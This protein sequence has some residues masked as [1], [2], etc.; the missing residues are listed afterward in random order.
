MYI[1]IDDFTDFTLEVTRTHKNS[2]DWD[3]KWCEVTLIIENEYFKY[4]IYNNELLL[5]SEIE[6]LIEK[7]YKWIN[8]ELQDI[9]VIDFIEPDLE[10]KLIPGE[11]QGEG[12]VDMKI[13]LFQDGV[14]S[15]DYYNLCLAKEEI[16]DILG[17]LN[18]VVSVVDFKYD[19]NKQDKYCILS[20]KYDDYDG[21]KIY[22]YLLTRKIEETNVGDSVIVD[23]V[24][25][26][27][28][29]TIIKKEFYKKE[30][31]PYP[32]N[33]T[34]NVIEVLRTPEDYKKYMTGKNKKYKCPCCG[35]YT[36]SEVDSFEVCPVCYWEDDP[37][38]RG[39]DEYTGGANEICLKSAKKNYKELKVANEKDIKN[40]RCPY[41]TETEYYEEFNNGDEICDLLYRGS[42]EEICY[43]IKE[44][45]IE[46]LFSKSN[47]EI[48]IKI[49]K[50]GINIVGK[51]KLYPQY[52]CIKYFGY[53]FSYKELIKK[54]PNCGER[55]VDILYGMPMY[56]AFEK[57]ENKELFLGGC[58]IFKDVEQPIYHCY[59]CNR[60]YYKDLVN[61]EEVKP[62]DF[63]TNKNEE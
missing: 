60:N 62:L 42:K 12:I 7:L 46:Y 1:K 31:T 14:L 19:Y 45:E 40:V 24:G 53:E 18:T 49:N 52:K 8:N 37:I 51:P 54:C 28:K 59:N 3:D 48:S 27:V 47:R 9:E 26:K 17:Y 11:G 58:L 43:I 55:L 35:Y 34:K 13:N 32:I 61:Y 44:F 10:F 56:N 20:V 29:G 25:Q 16:K 50:I 5:E 38:Q 41:L 15:A 21:E 23:R 33:L 39:N 63:L 22:S 57:V 36:L 30:N 2:K 4:K 6:N